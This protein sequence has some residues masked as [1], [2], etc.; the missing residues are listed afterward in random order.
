MLKLETHPDFE[1]RYTTDGS[2]PKESGGTYK[3][4][5]TPIPEN[6]KYVNVAV[7]NKGHLMEE[8]QFPVEIHHAKELKIND[9]KQ[10]EYRL[11]NIKKINDTSEVFAELESLGKI[12]GAR[13]SNYTVNVSGK[14]GIDSYV[15]LQ[16][17]VEYAIKDL[18]N[19]I[20][21]VRT[22]GF[23]GKDSDV[24]LEYKSVHFNSGEAFRH[25]IDDEKLDLSE[26]SVKGTVIQ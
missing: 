14:G 23:S 5:E 19:M 18:L 4:D 8:K 15:E 16:S 1:V 24:C 11:T 12:E 22:T 3:N 9:K 20:D 6:C 25:W 10:L 7:Y 2:N 13:I 26:L 17:N 21:A